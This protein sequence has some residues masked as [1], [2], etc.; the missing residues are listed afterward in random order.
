MSVW[1][2]HITMAASILFR[3]TIIAATV[4]AAQRSSA[5]S[6]H[7]MYSGAHPKAEVLRRTKS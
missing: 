4:L 2:W 5:M 6:C 1:R 3:A 7:C